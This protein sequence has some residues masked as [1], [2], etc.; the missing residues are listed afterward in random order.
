MRILLCNDDGIEAPGLWHAVKEL[1][2][3]ELTVVTTLTDQSGASH[4]TTRVGPLR[5][6]KRV[7]NGVAATVV[8]GTPV[9]AVKFMLSH[10]ARPF[11]AMV[12]GINT[13]ENG[14]SSHYY[15]GT[16]AAAREAALRGVN[17]ISVSVWRD[18]A[19]HYQAAAQFVGK[20]LPRWLSPEDLRRPD[21]PTLLNVNFP[22]RDPTQIK[23]IH[24]ARQSIA[25][26]DDCFVKISEDD[27][28]AEYEIKFGCKN[29]HR[30]IHGSDDW[31]LQAGFI[32]VAPLRLETTCQT[33]LD[34]LGQ[35]HHIF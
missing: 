21:G 34:W 30:I 28:Q 3:H 15:S 10:T 32:T 4:S 13:G 24:V 14:G 17:A 5:V 11:D 23:G 35:V 9:D 12:A 7:V 33:S 26:F 29:P 22:D 1:H 18:E 25:Y 27:D 2:S 31:A 16:V 6:K 20:W 19:A 8:A